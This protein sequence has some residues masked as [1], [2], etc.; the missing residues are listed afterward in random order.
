MTIAINDLA[1]NEQLDARALVRVRGG[2]AIFAG[3]KGPGPLQGPHGHG[4]AVILPGHLFHKSLSNVTN[5]INIVVNSQNVS[6][7]N[8]NTVLQF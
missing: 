5:Q 3:H 8:S 1:Q 4:P 6:Q 2:K 7:S